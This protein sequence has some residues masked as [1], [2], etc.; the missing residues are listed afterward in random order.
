MKRTACQVFMRVLRLVYRLTFLLCLVSVQ[1]EQEYRVYVPLV[2]VPYREPRHGAGSTYGVCF[3]GQEWVYDWSVDPPDCGESVPMIWGA[4]DI[5]KPLG[6]NSNWLMGFNEPSEKYQANLTPYQG[7]IY[8]VDVEQIYAD[9]KLTTPCEISLDWLT[10]W[11]KEFEGLT[12]SVPRVDSVCVHCYG[13]WDSVSGI[14]KCTYFL[15][16]AIRWGK[17]RGIDRVWLAEFA[18]FPCWPEGDQGTIDFMRGMLNYLDRSL[19]ITRY[20]WFQVYY[21]GDEPWAF[22][23][24][25]NTSLVNFKTGHL[26]AFGM[27]YSE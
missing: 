16:S 2:M 17:E 4:G 24:G 27:V 10:D 21:R 13:Y 14:R 23:E 8:W 7:A 25:C 20:A 12:G 5:G 3:E 18:F 19:E 6:G 9:Y 26:T 1:A 22:G 11:Y 15:D